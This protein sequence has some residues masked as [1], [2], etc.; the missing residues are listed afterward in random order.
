M[1]HLN[2]RDWI[3]APLLIVGVAFMFL[4]AIG[5]LRMPDVYTR[6]QAA[7]KTATLGL[8]TTSLAVAV[9]FSEPVVVVRALTLIVLASLTVPVAAQAICRAAHRSGV[10]LW[11][12]G[13]LDELRGEPRRD[14]EPPT[15]AP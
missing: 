8:W 7:S 14:E 15:G 4:G 13:A 5:L 1:D 10:P 3:A 11:P 12:A 2:V 6:M 9:H